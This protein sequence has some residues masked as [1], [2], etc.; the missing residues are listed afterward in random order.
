MPITLISSLAWQLRSL[1]HVTVNACR[2][3]ELLALYRRAADS[4]PVISSIATFIRRGPASISA[5]EPSIRRKITGLLNPRT[6]ISC[7]AATARTDRLRARGQLMPRS[8]CDSEIVCTTAAFNSSFASPRTSCNFRRADF[9]DLPAQLAFFH[10]LHHTRDIFFEAL[11]H[12]RK[13]RFQFR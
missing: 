4:T 7:P 10:R 5:D 9:L 6:R 1:R 11:L 12:F 3:L 2:V 8:V 13:L